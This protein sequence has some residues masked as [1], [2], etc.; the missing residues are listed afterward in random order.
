MLAPEAN[1]AR[2]ARPNTVT[3]WASPFAARSPEEGPRAITFQ[4]D[5]YPKALSLLPSDRS[6]RI[7]DV[8]AGEGYFCKLAVEDGREIE[9]CDY[10]AEQ[11]RMPSVPFHR[12]DLAQGIP[13]PDNAYDVVVAIEVIEH[14]EDHFR[15]VRELLRVLKP[16]GMLIITTPNVVSLSS[17]IH[18]LLY[19]YND[20][21]P[22][23]LDPAKPD[24]H[25]QHI[26][27][28]ALPQM[29]YLVERYGGVVESVA[30]NRA[31][32]SAYL[33][34]I[35]RPLLALLLRR[36]LLKPKYRAMLPV[37]RRH[38]RWMLSRPALMGRISILVAAKSAESAPISSRRPSGSFSQTPT[39]R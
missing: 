3:D 20:C 14:M 33:P 5:I 35:G 7:L 30:T 11:F 10:S 13:L 37:Y 29:L 31:R 21:A 32:R 24:Q 23:P 28:I 27:A 2:D 25:N 18:F 8:G 16:G 22:R 26:N 1:A 15:F 36:K 34:M 12:A 6:Q 19:G 4:P 17:R 9:A 38:I 39:P